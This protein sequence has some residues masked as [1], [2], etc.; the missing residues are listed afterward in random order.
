[1]VLH[2]TGI[3][4]NPTLYKKIEELRRASRELL[5]LGEA[6]GLCR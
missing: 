1:M 2:E 6:D 5:R 4:M 3:T